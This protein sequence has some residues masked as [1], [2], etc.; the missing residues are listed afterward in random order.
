[1][2]TRFIEENRRPQTRRPKD[3]HYPLFVDFK[4]KPRRVRRTKCRLSFLERG[5]RSPLCELICWLICV[6]FAVCAFIVLLDAFG[7]VR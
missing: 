5:Y 6:L 4:W 2:P 1:M 3:Q 7:G